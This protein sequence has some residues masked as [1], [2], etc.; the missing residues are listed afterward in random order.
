MNAQGEHAIED[1]V[2]P[3]DLLDP[4]FA[5]ADGHG[6]MTDAILVGQKGKNSHVAI[7]Q[8]T[9]IDGKY[10]R[11]GGNNPTLNVFHEKIRALEGGE[12]ATS[13]TC[14]MAIISQTLHALLSS[15]VRVV[16]HQTIYSHTTALLIDYRDRFGIELEFVD[17]KDLE[18]LRD[19]LRAKKTDFVYFEPYANPSMDV[20]DAPTIIREAKE[21]GALTILDNT[22]LSPYLLQP[23]RYGADL[24]LQSAT[25]YIS[26]GSAM[27]GV[28]SGNGKLIKRIEKMIK[29]MGGILRPYDASLILEGLKTLGMRMERC[30]ASALEV[31]RYLEDHRKVA[32]VHYGGLPSWEGYEVGSTY[33]RGFG[34]MMGVKWKDSGTES[35]FRGR[36]KM[37]KNEGSYGDSATRVRK[38]GKGYT[39]IA[40]GLE[41]PADIIAD[42]EQALA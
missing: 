10:Q 38:R 40:I 28:V 21:V 31:A 7:H 20:L 41:D 12:S 6:F 29:N 35:N 37:F 19:T 16:A 27:G 9:N 1:S 42:I 17:M 14:G 39:R 15:G 32:R 36:V 2:V 33:L 30:T 34:G 22:F 24:V 5:S 4:K 18:N 26:G 13:A 3:Q 8:Q 25:K 11:V 23:L